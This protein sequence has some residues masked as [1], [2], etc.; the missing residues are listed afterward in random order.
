M[1]GRRRQADSSTWSGSRE[2]VAEAVSGLSQGMNSLVRGHLALARLEITR[3]LKAL[4]K[5]ATMELGGLPMLWASYLLL[6]MGIGYWLA[7]EIPMWASFLL[8]S[9]VNLLVG[10]VLMLWGYRRSKR[11]R[12]GMPA[13]VNEVRKDREWASTLREA[14]SE[15]RSEAR[16]RGLPGRETASMPPLRQSSPSLEGAS[17]D[18]SMVRE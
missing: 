10:S 18:T 15:P 8:C 2:S 4:G 5:D 1:D 9:A 16:G 3:D 6:W 14:S 13:T 7:Q 12:S 11:D 17:R